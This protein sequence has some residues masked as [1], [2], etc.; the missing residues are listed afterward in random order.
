MP[1]MAAA[2]RCSP[3]GIPP[4][5][6]VPTPTSTPAPSPALTSTPAP[7][8]TPAPI[9]APTPA[10]TPAPTHSPTPAPT[11][12][13]TPAP[14]CATEL[15]IVPY[16]SLSLEA[17]KNYSQHIYVTGGTG[18]YQLAITESNP[19]LPAGLF[20]SA[21]GDLI[22]PSGLA[23]S[24]YTLT[25]AAVDSQN[26]STNVTITL[27]FVAGIPPGEHLIAAAIVG[28]T[29]SAILLIYAC[30]AIIVSVLL[31]KQYA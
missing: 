23:N 24:S 17:G 21:T 4:T 7:T 14:N 22:V 27:K 1:T 26:C 6:S 12:S 9:S 2:M 3:G 11:L 18:P 20:I 16:G 10:P 29:L 13:P 19:S 25:I 28:I 31:C 8:P 30:G 5:P 15:D